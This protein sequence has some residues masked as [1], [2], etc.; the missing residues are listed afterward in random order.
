LVTKLKGGEKMAKGDRIR[1]GCY[2]QWG[3]ASP[4]CMETFIQPNNLP[5]K[6]CPPCQ[7]IARRVSGRLWMRKKAA[8]RLTDPF[9]YPPIVECKCPR[10]EK[11][12]NMRIFWTGNG[13]PRKNCHDCQKTINEWGDCEDYNVILERR[14]K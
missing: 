11:V 3:E 9:H 14:R 4:D 13:R 6:N 10:C 5:V 12:S 7:P 8:G 1:C 2:N